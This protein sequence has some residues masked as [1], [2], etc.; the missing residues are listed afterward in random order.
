MDQA[1]AFFKARFSSPGDFTFWFVGNYDEATLIPLMEKYLGSVA[2]SGVTE[3]WTDRGVRPPAGM[4]DEKV[5]KEW[6]G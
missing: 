4:V 1:L 6:E 2:A 3:T 5:K